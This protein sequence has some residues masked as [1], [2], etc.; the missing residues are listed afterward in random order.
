MGEKKGERERGSIRRRKAC[1]M[2]LDF[3]GLRKDEILII[4]YLTKYNKGLYISNTQHI[5]HM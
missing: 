1:G 2:L 4:N 5:I 3:E